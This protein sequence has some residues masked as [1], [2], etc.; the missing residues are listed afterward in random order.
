M[1]PKEQPP[2]AHT[3]SSAILT[4]FP[5]VYAAADH[6]GRLSGAV[7]YDPDHGKV[8]VVHFVGSTMQRTPR[9]GLIRNENKERGVRQT[10]YDTTFD[11]Q[12]DEQRIQHT[13]YNKRQIRDGSLIPANA[14]TARLGGVR[15]VDPNIA[16]AEARRKLVQELVS[17][18]GEDVANEWS[19]KWPPYRIGEEER[20][21]EPTRETTVEPVDKETEVED[22][23]GESAKADS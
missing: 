22:V 17:L 8:G 5:N 4:V 16:L 9:K 21:T 10:M 23:D 18:Y 20:S 2:I 11:F 13:D 3:R 12:L 7:R 1:P 14:E 6:L 19:S 15:F